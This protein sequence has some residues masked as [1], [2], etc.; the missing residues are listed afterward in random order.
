MDVKLLLTKVDTVFAR[1]PLAPQEAALHILGA[2]VLSE[3][4]Q[5]LGVV[6]GLQ[7]PPGHLWPWHRGKVYGAWKQNKVKICK[8]WEKGSMNLVSLCM[9]S[10]LLNM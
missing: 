3:G 8:T 10:D 4:E 9:I 2:W 6:I 5:G 7:L 1:V